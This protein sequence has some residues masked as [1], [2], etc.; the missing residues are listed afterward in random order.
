[1]AQP[2]YA[3][4]LYSEGR[5]PDAAAQP[6]AHVLFAGAQEDDGGASKP[7]M[8]AT[9]AE[10]AA[11]APHLPPES[12]VIAQLLSPQAVSAYRWA[13]PPGALVFGALRADDAALDRCEAAGL[14]VSP[15]MEGPHAEELTTQLQ[16]FFRHFKYPEHKAFILMDRGF[17]VFGDD[18]E[19][20]AATFDSDICTA[21]LGRTPQMLSTAPSGGAGSATG[22]A[23]AGGALGGLAGALGRLGGLLSRAHSE[24][25]EAVW[26][27]PAGGGAS[28]FFGGPVLA[29]AAASAAGPAGGAGAVS[30]PSSPMFG[31]LQAARA[32]F[33]LR[34]SGDGAGSGGGA[35]GGA[36]A[37][38]G[39]K[40]PQLPASIRAPPSVTKGSGGSEMRIPSFQTGLKPW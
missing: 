16:V 9:Q 36:G 32:S 22:S 37:A 2:V 8:P 14:P 40:E 30:E 34:T 19:D 7:L 20:A 39:G 6:P 3:A 13:R 1:M 33:L 5:V 27:V 26:V 23:G 29:G 25:V 28:G 15:S 35:A 17:F 21:L 18:L 10:L 11:G 38:C 12:L 24:P 4:A 31:A